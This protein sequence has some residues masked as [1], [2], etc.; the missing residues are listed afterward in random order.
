MLAIIRVFTTKDEGI[1]QSHSRIISGKYG[2]KTCTYCIPDQPYGIYDE[3][4]ELQAVPKIV[5]AAKQAEL[6]GATAILISCAAD[7]AIEA[8]R[9][10]VTIPVLGAGSSAAGIGLALGNRVG[11][12]NL[13]GPTPVRMAQV[14]GAHL[15][16][17]MSPTGVKNTTDLLTSTG[18]SAAIEAVKKLAREVDVIVFACTGYTTIGLLSDLNGQLDI[19]IVDAVQAGGAVAHSLF[20]ACA[21]AATEQVQL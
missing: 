18:R 10:A 9:Q 5:A 4:T 21:A 6:E 12:L 20:P 8:A 15:I 3:Q 17:E 11:V 14:L 13:S 1:L 7:P 19:P 2:L 16:M